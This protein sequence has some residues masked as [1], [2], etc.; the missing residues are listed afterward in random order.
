MYQTFFL[1]PPKI[2]A[3]SQFEPRRF[4]SGTKWFLSGFYPLILA[5]IVAVDVSLRK[6]KNIL[7]LLL[8][9]WCI[10]GWGVILLQRSAL[11]EYHYLLLFVPVGILATKGLDVLWQSLKKL[12]SLFTTILL[13]FLF[14]LPLSYPLTKKS[15]FLV[16][17]NFALSEDTRLKY[18]TVFREEYSSLRL[19]ADFISQPG[20]LP[21]NIYVAGDPSIYYFSGRLQS[22]S[23]RGW[24]L[25]Y[26]LPEQWVKLLEQ[27]ESSKPPY[28]FID[29]VHQAPPYIF[30][31]YVHQ[32]IIKEKFPKMLEFLEQRYSILRQNNNGIW[33]IFS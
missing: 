30:I 17:N 5:A 32:A 13:I 16:S 10:F 9:I 31:D 22:T 15:Y 27:L 1:Y 33:Y 6:S 19:E 14:S 7:T 11:W 18:Q 28:I 8:V 26:F 24:A 20:S 4:F 12:S 25:E 23:M 21:G 29:Y 2:I 3:N